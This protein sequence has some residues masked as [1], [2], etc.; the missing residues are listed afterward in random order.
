M[1]FDSLRRP[2]EVNEEKFEF[3]A[4]NE[5]N[6][7]RYDK[8]PISIRY[9]LEAAV[10]KCDGFHVK[11]EDVQTL[12]NWETTQH[13]DRE[14]PF[15]PARVLL[16]DF[17]GVP[18]VVDLASMRDAV[19]EL[20]GKPEVINPICPVDLVIDHSVQ[21]DTYGNLEA[22][23]K[24]QH[25]EFE[26]NK[27]RFNFL[28][29]GAEAFH[30]LRIVPPGSGI[31]H[32][33][34]LEYLGSGAFIDEPNRLIYP[35][36]VV[37]TDCHT[38]MIDGLG[39]LGWG[40]GGIEAEAVMLGFFV[41][42][43][44]LSAGQAI[45]FVVPE[46][47]GYRL[48]GK[49]PSMAT[50]TDL[51]LTIT[52]NLRQL[53]VVGKFIEF[54]G[55]GVANLSIADRATI[56]NMCPNTERRS[57][58]SRSTDGQS[59]TG[60]DKRWLEA[61]ETPR[62]SSSNYDDSSFAPNYTKVIELDLSTVVPSM[63]GPKRPHDRVV[64]ADL[65]QEFR[66]GLTEKISFKG[67]GLKAEEADKSVE[68]RAGR[69]TLHSAT[70]RGL[71][72]GHHLLHE[73]EQPVRDA[74]RRPR[75]RKA[76]AL[77][78]K[79]PAFV[80]T[81]LSPG[82]GVVTK[83]LE[84]SGLLPD[85]E[86][87]G[88]FITG[89]GCQTCIGN[90]G[91]LR[92]EVAKAIEDNDLIVSGVLSGNRNFEGRIHPHVRANYLASPP[93]VV[94]YG[95]AGRVDI[96]LEKEP[97]GQGTNGP[98]YF[99]DIWPSHEEVVQF[100]ENYVKPQFFREVYAN[101]QTGSPEWQQ[102]VCPAGALY[103]WNPESTYIKRVPFFEGMTFDPPPQKE[104]K[105]AF[106]LLNLGDSVT[107]DHISPAGSIARTSPAAKYL[108]ERGVTPRDFNTYGARRG[109]D[110]VM[111]RGTFANIRLVNK[112]ASKVGP[113]TL[114]VPSGE[115]LSVYD[116][117]ERY[118]AD[119]HQVIILAGK[120]FG[121]GSSR[122]WA[123]KGQLLQGVKAVIAISFE[124]IHRSNLIG[125]GI[126]PLQFLEGESAES[127]GLTGKERFTIV[128]PENVKPGQNLVVQT[129]GGAKFNVKFRCD[130]EVELAYL[131]HGGV[132]PYMV[133]KLASKQA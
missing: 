101:I 79:V 61:M 55:S 47:I 103:A 43:T 95:L 16:Q 60:R 82:S 5:L 74:R 109:H 112:L 108:N 8:L 129:D 29:W 80:K 42:Y 63:S 132:L 111:T 13:E 41:C 117:A 19:R 1:A 102:L 110:E 104:I 59:Q 7:P 72:F 28:K 51:V 44:R 69:R 36:S 32:Q 124:R 33:V 96:D 83:Y 130:T 88:Y 52:Q 18:A 4:I 84:S 12:F 131:R 113:T 20:G 15:V 53:G 125:M 57:A 37:G 126:I 58:S 70:R 81:S 38:T 3:Y 66:R 92:E 68:A 50:S 40:V 65:H 21:V 30:N 105:D 54:F 17:T 122:D 26:R 120:E 118:E 73:H 9:L 123:A 45:S 75:R 11:E 62:N 85:L 127:L 94:V 34:N 67:F 116:A 98:V 128:V 97:I 91:P 31:V 99:R 114:H 89:Y 22:L 90:S 35:D 14:I 133:R 77:G 106:V 24:N 107:T 56:A 64:L 87:L 23:Q 25:I 100:E 86:K 71:H 121:S 6:D 78:L 76:V 27:E 49:L 115:E 93:L 10:R 119:G 39:C 46:V 48:V 2:I